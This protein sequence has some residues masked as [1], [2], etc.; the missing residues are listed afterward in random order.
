MPCYI[1][2]VLYYYMPVPPRTGEWY[3]RRQVVL[4]VVLIKF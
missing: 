1:P 2:T 4:V 3:L